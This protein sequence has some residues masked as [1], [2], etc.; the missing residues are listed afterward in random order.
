VQEP[1]L[2]VFEG[3]DEKSDAFRPTSKGRGSLHLLGQLLNIETT[4]AKQLPE[5]PEVDAEGCYDL[6]HVMEYLKLKYRF[7][8]HDFAR[9]SN[10]FEN[11]CRR[12]GYKSRDPEGNHRRS[13][14]LWYAE[15]CE[16][17]KGGPMR[18]MREDFF[19]WIH[20]VVRKDD[21]DIKSFTLSIRYYLD[22]YDLVEAPAKQLEVER[23]NSIYTAY[24]AA[25]VP[26]ELKKFVGK[27]ILPDAK[28]PTFVRKI[29]TY[30][31]DEFGATPTL[32]L[33]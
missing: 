30:I 32:K 10:H 6:R 26:A 33:Q 16:D 11:W 19:E 28:L 23:V 18:P 2:F 13:S 29:L 15:Y 22:L 9:S 20:K 5:K 31:R 24:A 17:P 3:P 25:V 27:R 14:K 4:M 7:D 8:P 21:H 1:D 12:K